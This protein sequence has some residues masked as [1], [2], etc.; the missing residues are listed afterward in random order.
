MAAITRIFL[1]Q[2]FVQSLRPWPLP[3]PHQLK[4]RNL[5]ATSN[6]QPVFPDK[7]DD[8]LYE[9]FTDEYQST[10]LT[11]AHQVT[12]SYPCDALARVAANHDYEHANRLL[13]E[14]QAAKLTILHRREYENLVYVGLQKK[15][16]DNSLRWLN[17]LPSVREKN[18]MQGPRRTDLIV[19][20][21]RDKVVLSELVQVLVV[22]ARKGWNGPVPLELIGLM[23][24]YMPPSRFTRVLDDILRLHAQAY[25][26]PTMESQDAQALWSARAVAELAKRNQPDAAF[27]IFTHR[28][29]D[30]M[31]LDEAAV[32]ALYHSARRNASTTI[33]ALRVMITPSIWHQIHEYTAEVNQRALTNTALTQQAFQISVQHDDTMTQGSLAAIRRQNVNL[34][35]ALKQQ[36][37]R[38]TVENIHPKA[39]AYFF[40]QLMRIEN[41][42]RLLDLFQRR[43]DRLGGSDARSFWGTVE[44]ELLCY[45]DPLSAIHYYRGVFHPSGSPTFLHSQPKEEQEHLTKWLQLPP[46]CTRPLPST[47]LRPSSASLMTVWNAAITLA[48][49]PHPHVSTEDSTNESI[50]P[51]APTQQKDISNLVSVFIDF[52]SVYDHY[53]SVNRTYFSNPHSHIRYFELFLR[54]FVRVAPEQ[55]AWVMQAIQQRN[56]RLDHRAWAIYAKSKVDAGDHGFMLRIFDLLEKENGQPDFSPA[57]LADLSNVGKRVTRVSTEADILVPQK[58]FNAYVYGFK[59]LVKKQAFEEAAELHQR[60]LEA[61]YREGTSLSFDRLTHELLDSMRPYKRRERARMHEEEDDGSNDVDSIDEWR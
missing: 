17:L 48:L 38:D 43:V 4:T 26:E 6:L 2:F 20:L 50:E 57:A 35:R 51:I 56:V 44:T 11:R 21:W 55:S 61:G 23:A 31:R 58:V 18:G 7:L 45:Q 29:A 32:A 33:T 39:V 49:Q 47:R 52:L 27:H 8:A 12:A 24:R 40:D 36:L 25:D 60:I 54:A 19:S 34:V 28:A 14:F 15:D 3:N 10:T 53:T 59:Q 41:R 9:S 46:R 42:A 22:Y 1:P 30:I 16:I 5:S 37:A 13:K